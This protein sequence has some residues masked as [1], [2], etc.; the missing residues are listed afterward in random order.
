MDLDAGRSKNISSQAEHMSQIMNE[1][2]HMVCS[3]HATRLKNNA[4][5]SGC[6]TVDATIT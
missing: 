1:Q 2:P 4:R 5:T 6:W 3:Y